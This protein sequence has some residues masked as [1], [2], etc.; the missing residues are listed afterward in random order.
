M[1]FDHL[2]TPTEAECRFINDK[3]AIAYLNKFKRRPAADINEKFPKIS[4][5]GLNLLYYMLQFNPLLRPTA[6]DCLKHSYFDNIREKMLIP[7]PCPIKL[8]EVEGSIDG[9]KIAGLREKFNKILGRS[10]QHAT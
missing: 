6:S 7:S 9:V 10:Q 8:D 5:K 1:I 4:K 2:G 3:Q